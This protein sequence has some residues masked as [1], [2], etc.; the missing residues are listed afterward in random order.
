MPLEWHL[1]SY[2]AVNVPDEWDRKTFAVAAML[3]D[4]L[5]KKEASAVTSMQLRARFNPMLGDGVLN[6]KFPTRI[7][8]DEMESILKAMPEERLQEAIKEARL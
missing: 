3:E 6:F 2:L 4:E 5:F 8:A 7:E 1:D